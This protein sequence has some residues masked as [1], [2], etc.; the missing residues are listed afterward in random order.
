MAGGSSR[1]FCAEDLLLKPGPGLRLAE[2][3]Q[4][5][6]FHSDGIAADRAGAAIGLVFRR[7][8]EF[9]GVGVAFALHLADP[10]A[11]IFACLQR[12][13]IAVAAGRDGGG[14]AGD[15]FP[16]AD[17]RLFGEWCPR[18]R[19]APRL[20]WSHGSYGCSSPGTCRCDDRN[21]REII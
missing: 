18:W 5:A 19:A 9:A 11:G 20:E 3:L 12:H 6:T 21:W 8:G 17:D 1:H 7:V 4:H 14:I 2:Y 13:A 16:V 10:F 15:G